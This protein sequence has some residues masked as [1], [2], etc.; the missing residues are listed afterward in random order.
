[1]YPM[2]AVSRML[3][4][5]LVLLVPEANPVLTTT[6]SSTACRYKRGTRTTVCVTGSTSS[7]IS[8]CG[9]G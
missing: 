5:Y 2:N 4:W 8:E 9:K 6:D 1:M 3:K 7:F